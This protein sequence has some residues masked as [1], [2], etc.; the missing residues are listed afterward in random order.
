MSNGETAAFAAQQ[1]AMLNPD[2]LFKCTS[3]CLYGPE[4]Y[5]PGKAQMKQILV[6]HTIRHARVSLCSLDAVWGEV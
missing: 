3:R 4:F 6:T 2:V 1:T 5:S